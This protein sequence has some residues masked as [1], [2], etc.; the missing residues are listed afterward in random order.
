[1]SKPNTV[2]VVAHPGQGAGWIGEGVG[3]EG[4]LQ[5]QAHTIDP[6]FQSVEHIAHP[7]DCM[8]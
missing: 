6:S 3:E 4:V 5:S 7:L 8:F 1:M 2:T